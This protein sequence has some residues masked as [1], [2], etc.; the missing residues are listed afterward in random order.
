M[1][2]NVLIMGAAGRDFHNFNVY[3]RD[4]ESYDVK[5]FTATQIPNI[6]DR[7]YPKELAGT[8]YPKGIDIYPEEEL[9]DL[10]QK[11]SIQVV[12]FSYSDQPHEVVMN[13]AS[14]VNAVGA[15]FWLMGYN[16]TALRSTKPVISV[17]AVRTGSGKSQ[18]SRKIVK[19][20]TAMGKK[21]V[22]VR[23]PMP[24]G[25]LAEQAVQRFATLEDL[26]KHKCTIEEMEEY[27]PYIAMNAVIYAGV[28]YEK[29]LRSAEKEADIILW[30]GGNNDIPFYFSDLKFVV[31]D[32]T[33]PYHEISYY[34]GETNI[35]MADYIIINKEDSSNLEDIM[36]VREN[37][38]A[39]N[40]KAVIID[41]VSPIFV[42]NPEI[43][44]GKKVLVIEDGPTLTHGELSIG[45]GYLAA[46]KWGAQIVDPRPF[47]VGSIKEAYTK[48]PQIEEIIP[49]LGY[50]DKQIKELEET[51]NAAKDVDAVVI[52]TPIDLR[53]V[54]KIKKPS[55][56]VYYELEEIG[57]PKLEDII[58]QKFGK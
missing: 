19:I 34:P 16:Q 12:V 17:C 20:L 23:H 2:K 56:R 9:A 5:A 30:D 27:E 3:F 11:L 10:I 51:V 24:Y 4:N 42:E 40:P 8:L 45:A 44:Q 1:K 33:R 49:A 22:A 41:G 32:P 28:D 46:K 50:S 13:K 25:N 39:V 35:R 58:K 43:I 52:G 14:L 48:Y 6:D 47:T 31:A 53:R 54:I 38:M 7:K 29:I 55:V 37:C 21:V 15:D 57:E 18:T 36:A 26:K